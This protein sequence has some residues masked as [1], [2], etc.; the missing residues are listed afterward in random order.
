[1]KL[2][3]FKVMETFDLPKIGLALL[4]GLG[5]TYVPVGTTISIIR[6]DNSEIET[7]IT[8]IAFEQNFSITVGKELRKKDVPVGSEIWVKKSLTY[9]LNHYH[10]WSKRKVESDFEIIFQHK[11]EKSFYTSI[12]L[13]DVAGMRDHISS[14]PCLKLRIDMTGGS[15]VQDLAI[16]LKNEEIREYA[17]AFLFTDDKCVNFCFRG[18]ARE[19]TYRKYNFERNIQ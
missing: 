17:E 9:D 12:L 5:E 2:F 8:S 7:T 6:P 4:P 15:Y 13:T 16:Q 18:V 19:I 11:I 1:M 10:L 14:I 3:L